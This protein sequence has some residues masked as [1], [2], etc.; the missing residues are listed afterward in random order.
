MLRWDLTLAR[1]LSGK[2]HTYGT[3]ESRLLQKQDQAPSFSS[4]VLSVWLCANTIAIGSVVFSKDIEGGLFGVRAFN[5]AIK[6]LAYLQNAEHQYIS[7]PESV[8]L[9]TSMSPKIWEWLSISNTI[10]MKVKTYS[11]KCIKVLRKTMNA[12]KWRVA[13]SAVTILASID[14]FIS[15]KSIDRVLLIDETDLARNS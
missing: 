12:I 7:T 8:A 2:I 14:N 5:A 6:E 1:W 13:A 15:F 11:T 3:L 4:L 10:D 9:T